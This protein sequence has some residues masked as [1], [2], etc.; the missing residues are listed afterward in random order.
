MLREGASWSGRERNKV[1]WN[2]RD[3]RFAD[4]SA[5]SGLDLKHD[6]RAAARVDWDGDGLEDLV[7]VSRNSPRVRVFR[8][9]TPEAG[10]SMALWLEGAGANRDAVG[11]RIEVHVEDEPV[12]LAA[13]RSGEG[14]L[15]QSSRWIHIGLG[16]AERVERVVVRWPR[17]ASDEEP[18]VQVFEGLLKGQRVR[19]R[20]GQ[21]QA[22]VLENLEEPVELQA[23][24]LQLKAPTERGRVV[25]ASRLPLPPAELIRPGAPRI[26]LRAYAG[27]P[28][29]VCIF[30]S[31]CAPC[32]SELREL[33]SRYEELTGRG[34]R[35][36]A[37]S[38]DEL[39]D[40]TQALQLTTD[41]AWP[42]PVAFATPEAT[43]ALDV[44]QQVVVDRRRR[45]SLPSSF[46]VDASG[47]VA[48]IYRGALELDLLKS[49]LG[50]LELSP[51][52]LRS[53]A[54]PFEGRWLTK[55]LP[56]APLSALE[57]TY[58]ERGLELAAADLAR[59]QMEVSLISPGELYLQMGSELA[60]MGRMEDAVQ[61]FAEAVEADEQSVAA[62]LSL[63]AAQHQLGRLPEAIGG[64]KRVLRLDAGNGAAL[65][66]LALAHAAIGELETAWSEQEWLAT[67]DTAA[68]ERLKAQLERLGEREEP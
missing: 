6:A 37:V 26:D 8:N 53:A 12:R 51:Q 16:G 44:L 33:A 25:L 38:V 31:W 54:T 60:R 29:L 19:L 21:A 22:E 68:A 3:G 62:Q 20:E 7:V 43:E 39:E 34:L 50:L 2:S 42:W 23:K 9:R 48:A 36:L 61:R 46:L 47:D 64:Y 18:R 52:E 65:Y 11:A 28:M 4:V 10:S 55:T 56:V 27:E 13:V 59:R 67:V 14:Y 66:N 15:A 24:A 40:R 49:D 5:L 57:S 45:L 41:L 17:R 32:V 35:V 63:S 58:D 30:A 1:F